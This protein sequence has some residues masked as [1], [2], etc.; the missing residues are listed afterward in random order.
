MDPL[1]DT[2]RDRF[3]LSRFR[4]GQE[5]VIRHI[6][7]DQSVVVTMP[8][9]SGKSLCYQLP[10]L[11]AA[12]VTLVVS[13]L[14]ALMKDQVDA[15]NALGIPATY[16]N[17]TL[18]REETQKRFSLVQANK[19][20]LL[21]I[22]P[23]RFYSG[24][25][26]HLL[27]K[28]NV[29]LFIIDEAHCI[30]QWGHDFRPSYLRLKH[31]I[32]AVGNPPV[33]A[34][35]A[36]ATPEV[37]KDI[38]TQLG[39]DSMVDIVTGFDR[40]NLKYVA[41]SLKNDQE[42]EAE[43]LRILGRLQGSGI[44]YVGTKA[45]VESL[46]DLLLAEEYSAAGYHGG[47]D[48]EQRTHV[49]NQWIEGK[50][51]II[52][53]TNAFGMGIDKPDVR[54][55]FH[56]TMPGTLEAYMQESGRAGRDGKTAYCVAFTAYKDVRLQEF[57]IDNAHPPKESVLALYNYLHSLNLQDIYLTHRELA[58]RVGQD[59]K[60][61][62]VGPILAVLEKAGLLKRLNRNDHRMEI[63]INHRDADVRGSVQSRVF[64]YLIRMTENNAGSVLA[65]TPEQV[66]QDLKLTQAQ[67]STTLLAMQ[68]KG[69]IKYT[70][71][72]RGRGVRLAGE[73]IPTGK[74]PIDFG[75][76]EN[77]RRFQMRK[78]DDMQRYFTLRTCRRKYLLKYFGETSHKSNCGG[79]DICLDWKGPEAQRKPSS[80]VQN[81]TDI[82]ELIREILHLVDS[83]NDQY[84]RD[85]LAKT[86]AG[87][88]ARN[89][90]RY[91]R[92]HPQYGSYEHMTRKSIS[93][94]FM[95][96]LYNGYLNQ[97]QGL[98]PTLSLK[99]KG[100]RVLRNELAPPVIKIKPK[101]A[102]KKRS[103]TPTMTPS[104]E[105]TWDLYRKNYS[106]EEIAEHRGYTVSTIINHLCR[107]I[108]LGKPIDVGN[109]VDREKIPIIEEAIKK[110]QA[111]GLAAIKDNIP[112][113]KPCSYDEIK[114]VLVNQLQ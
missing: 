25:F 73:K 75:A 29:S 56:Y 21:Y 112:P 90:P 86:L 57:F 26:V 9:G 13:P 81:A 7:E 83:V 65:L 89:L 52:V 62:M 85:A 74:L 10:A 36:T 104:L 28:V 66:M 47:M 11:L 19:I 17:S 79:C 27:T 107:L 15:M 99:T 20:K 22:A 8:T 106:V 95:D 87:S 3:R 92:R 18:N 31:A 68:T 105:I 109:L 50:T 76:I 93:A 34:F 77:H 69:V 49:Q 82:G 40:K 72:F 6:M 67:I 1:Y 38:Q 37:R 5:E 98:Y 103:T 97:G 44:I 100:R 59:I 113:E 84:G 12:G 43:L 32:E 46:T 60:E 96:L 78:L 24:S 51:D 55:V 88:K 71:P 33:G 94:V 54:F 58:E 110:T 45:L 61:P 53:A 63:E 70:P 16:I 4:P 39:L 101:P 111:P 41:E 14:I 108:E 102:R 64:N 30:S 48:K 114:L 91:L 80:A 2:L 35:T 42:K 23:E